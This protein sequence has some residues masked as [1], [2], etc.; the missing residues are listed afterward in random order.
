MALLL[1]LFTYELP[2]YVSF[3]AAESFE[4]VFASIRDQMPSNCE[5]N[6]KKI[7]SIKQLPDKH[8]LTIQRK[9]ANIASNTFEIS[10]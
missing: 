2:L 1:N 10:V 6:R 9:G 3:I 7:S 4:N 8:L 5:P